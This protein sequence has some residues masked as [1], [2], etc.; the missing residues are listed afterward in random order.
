MNYKQLISFANDKIG[1]NLMATDE[2]FFWFKRITGKEH[3]A[4]LLH[5]FSKKEINKF[6]AIAKKRSRN[7]P[8]QKI[9]KKTDFLGVDIYFSRNT[10]SPRPE[11]E[12]LT[13][14]AMEYA[15]LLSSAKKTFPNLTDDQ[16][17]LKSTA[18]LDKVIK[19]YEMGESV[20]FSKCPPADN[21]HVLDICTGSGCIGL[22]AKMHTG[23]IVTLADKSGKALANC[24]KNAR[25]N[26]LKVNI[27]KSDLFSKIKDDFDIIISNP[28]YIKTDQIKLL[29]GEVTKFDPIMALDGGADG[30]EFYRKIIADA[31]HHFKNPGV[32]FLEIDEGLQKDIQKL[33][34]K[35]C[36]YIKILTDFSGNHRF[37]V[38]QY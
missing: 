19:N 22:A 18:L 6:V 26:K 10:L 15:V 16:F 13:V 5:E 12:I 3:A 11:T 7:I 8:Y 24:K 35:N 14:L 30:L 34:E 2:C 37:C 4:V 21:V 23:A 29:S 17:A 38:C 28:P 32:L 36:K 25:K 9:C 1:N 33:L 27:V 31:K 20:D